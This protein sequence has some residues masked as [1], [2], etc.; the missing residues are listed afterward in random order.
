MLNLETPS[1]NLTKS[2][3]DSGGVAVGMVVRLMRGVE[4]AAIAKSAGF[5]C[6]YIDLEHCSF[7]LE[8][9]SQ[10]SLTATALG[11]TPLVRVPGINKT[12]I[13]R[14]LETGAQG[15]IVP[16]VENRAQ[17]EEIVDASRFPPRGSRSLLATN[18][19]TLFRGGPAA[20]VME[21]MEAATLVVGMIESA[22]AVENSDDIA[23]VDGMDM[24]L[25]GTNDLCNSFGVPGE[26]DHPRV[27]EAYEHVAAVCRARGKHLGVGGLNSRPEL[28]K[29]MIR[30]GGR[31]V[32]AGSDTGFL[33]SAAT[34]TARLFQ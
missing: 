28:A 26:L 5:D 21:K 33:M 8:T 13:G 22:T 2:K 18:A 11:V 30:L 14:V 25:V 6:L 10:I 7:S 15:V 32:S 12:E 9:V 4:I 31:Y 27:R 1:K 20:E 17:A 29:E 23:S 24:L 34:A 16:H 19:H 3:M